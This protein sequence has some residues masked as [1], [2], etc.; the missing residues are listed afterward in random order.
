MKY[1]QVLFTVP[2][3]ERTDHPTTWIERELAFEGLLTALRAAS[4]PADP[5]LQLQAAGAPARSA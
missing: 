4:E 5:G 3:R 2:V 1:R